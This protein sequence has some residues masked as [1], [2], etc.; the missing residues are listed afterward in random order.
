[1]DE[2][3]D[4]ERSAVAVPLPAEFLRFFDDAVCQFEL[5]LLLPGVRASGLIPSLR[6]AVTAAEG[7]AGPHADAGADGVWV[8][9]PGNVPTSRL[10]GVPIFAPRVDAFCCCC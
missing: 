4:E 9:A 6:A 2:A 10:V 8:V 5:L 1:M 3:V 7:G